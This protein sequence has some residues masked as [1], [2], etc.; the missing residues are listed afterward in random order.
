MNLENERSRGII[1]QNW[2]NL[3]FINSREYGKSECGINWSWVRSNLDDFDVWYV[4][5]GE[6]EIHINQ[7]RYEASQGTCCIL[8]PGDYIEAY[9][10]PDNRLILIYFHF[11]LYDLRVEDVV[12]DD[13]TLPPRHN[14]VPE[15]Y[16]IEQFLH[17][18]LEYA[19]KDDAYSEE[20][21]HHLLKMIMTQLFYWKNKNNRTQ[22]RHRHLMGTV[23]KHIERHIARPIS[24]EELAH[25]VSLSPRYVSRLFKEYSG[26]S[27][28]EYITK[29]RLERA[30][31]LLTETDKNVTQVAEALGYKDIYWFSNQFKQLYGTSPSNYKRNA[32][33]SLQS[34]SPIRR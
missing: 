16:W 2:E 30:R 24:H 1:M 19:D 26:Y 13:S 22:S 9:Q 11:R 28:K 5:S 15:R 23:V 6:G 17:C 4:L 27:L 20:M 29:T 33:K 31:K 18:L 34:P 21:I 8:R 10:N 12:T 25:L 32:R 14:I 7:V 3:R